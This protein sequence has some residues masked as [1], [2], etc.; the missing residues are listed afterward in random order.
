MELTT[1]RRLAA[2]VLKCAPK[3]VWFDPNR[4][5]EVKESITKADMRGMVIK[6]VVQVL[7]ARSNSRGRMRQHLRQKRKGRRTGHGSRRGTANARADVKDAWINRVRKQRLFLHNLVEK[8]YID[9]NTY[10]LLY[11]KSKGGYFRSE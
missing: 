8:K 10:R 7:P 1:Q 5:N 3:R 2:A 9:S 6:G 11:R 4:L